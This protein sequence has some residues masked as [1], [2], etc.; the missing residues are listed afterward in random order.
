MSIVVRT[1]SEQVFEIVREQI[2]TGKLAGHTAIRQDALA[3]E[4]GVS[5]IPLR[6]ALARLEQEGLLTSHANRGYSVQPMSADEADDI[7][8]L[9]LA[10]EPQAAAYAS[11]VAND[12]DRKAA[13]LAFE[14]LDSAASERLAE[15]AIRNRVFHTALVRPGRRLLTTQMVERLAIIAERYVVAHL[16]PAGREDRAHLEHRQLLDAWLARDDDRM[17]TLLNSHIQSTLTD[18]RFQFATARD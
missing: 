13:I 9:R 10:I 1:L 5:K 16:R 7:F 15:V 14:E 17:L 12:D 4:L 6:E 8:A 3:T 11:T 2:V 18:L